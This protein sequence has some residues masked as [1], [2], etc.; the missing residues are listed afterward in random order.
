MDCKNWREDC[1][2]FSDE[3]DGLACEFFKPAMTKGIRD[4]LLKDYPSKKHQKTIK[5]IYK[6]MEG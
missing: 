6:Y 4:A 1:V 3:E 2:Y 5:A